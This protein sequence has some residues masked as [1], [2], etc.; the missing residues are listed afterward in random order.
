MPAIRH[1]RFREL[2]LKFAALAIGLAIWLPLARFVFREDVARFRVSSGVAAKARALAARHWALWTDPERRTRELA[3]MRKLNPEWDFMSRTF[4]VLSVCN[5]ALADRGYRAQGLELV[6]AILDDT[7]A[8]E[9]AKGPEGFLLGY[10]RT[11]G[12]WVVPPGRSQFIDGEI[13]LMLAARRLVAEKPEYRALLAERIEVMTRRMAGSP[14]LNAESYPD[15]CWLFCNTIAL[16]A[17]R[18]ADV[19]DGSD[20]RDLLATWVRVAREKLVDRKTGLLIS[21]YS[22]SGR[23]AASGPGPEG[24]SIWL[25]AHMLQVVDPAFARDQYDRARRELGRSPLGFGYA[26]EWPVGQ[27]EQPDVDSGPVV[28]LFGASAAA[29]GLAIVAAA[30][31]D[32]RDYLQALL[33]ALNAFGFPE[34]RD[35]RLRY[36]ASNAVGDAVLLYALTLGPLWRELDRRAQR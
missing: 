28:P 11:T 31:F 22:V 4:V 26:L 1:T 15:E 6:D 8:F 34:E 3:S 5:M 14:V 18:A 33:T 25:A 29:S 7:L 35:G 21:A 13:A 16:A 19:L 36:A 9:R 32:D 23:P 10:V 2:C 27:E 17:I 20:H 30:A 24:S 12:P